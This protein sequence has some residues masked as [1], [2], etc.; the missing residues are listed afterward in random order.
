M[1][2]SG[3]IASILEWECKI[4]EAP[5]GTHSMEGFALLAMFGEMVLH[6]Y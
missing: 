2:D 4:L 1:N 3:Q 5:E 6:L